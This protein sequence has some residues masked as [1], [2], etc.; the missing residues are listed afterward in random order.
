MWSQLLACFALTLPL[1]IYFAYM[2]ATFYL[3]RCALMA[4]TLISSPMIKG[5]TVLVLLRLLDWLRTT[6]CSLLSL[7]VL[8]KRGH[9]NAKRATVVVKGAF[10]LVDGAS[11]QEDCPI[12]LENTRNERR[13]SVSWRKCRQCNHSFHTTCLESWVKTGGS[14]CPTCRRAFTQ[15]G[16]VRAPH[17]ESSITVTDFRLSLFE[18]TLHVVGLCIYV[19]EKARLHLEVRKALVNFCLMG[20]L[21]TAMTVSIIVGVLQ[22]TTHNMVMG[23]RVTESGVA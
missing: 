17:T 12:C 22:I 9:H 18:F 19:A 1:A 16:N 4:S 3:I 10:T 11:L 5:Y 21:S 14:C 15:R 23:G 20:L 13:K 6:T 2:S 8:R 7:G